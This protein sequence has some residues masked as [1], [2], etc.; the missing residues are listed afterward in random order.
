M[1]GNLNLLLMLIAVCFEGPVLSNYPQLGLSELYAP[2]FFIVTIFLYK[3]RLVELSRNKEIPLV[4][5]FFVLLMAPRE[6]AISNSY[7]ILVCKL[8]YL[9]FVSVSI[10]ITVDTPIKLRMAIFAI[11]LCSFFGSLIIAIIEHIN[12]GGGYDAYFLYRNHP[13]L[14]ETRQLMGFSK[15][16]NNLALNL[17]PLLIYMALHALY[18]KAHKTTILTR[19]VIFILLILVIILSQSKSLLLGLILVAFAISRYYQMG[20][21]LQ[22]ALFSVGVVFYFGLVHFVFLASGSHSSTLVGEFL[23]S[24]YPICQLTQFNVFISQYF[25]LKKIAL[26]AFFNHPISGIGLGKFGNY[27]ENFAVENVERLHTEN[28]LP[29]SLYF[30]LFAECG[31]LTGIIFLLFSFWFIIKNLSDIPSPRRRH[32]ISSH[33]FIRIG[34]LFFL[35]EGFNLDVQYNRYFW[36]LIGSMIAVSHSWRPEIGKPV[37]RP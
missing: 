17:V 30:S 15:T 7:A 11:P 14:G 13:Y 5:I 24:R 8:F 23:G 32:L 4:L 12:P 18:E 9:V 20:K 10:A 22:K 31:F 19:G 2:I 34:V 16:P 37:T 26:D 27:A 25:L 6:P 1:L 29:H 35:I 21:Q 36:I 28:P 3:E 33:V